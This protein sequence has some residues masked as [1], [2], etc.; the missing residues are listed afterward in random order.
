MTGLGPGDRE[1]A[2]LASMSEAVEVL[3]GAELPEADLSGAIGI[4]SVG[5]LAVV[6]DAEAGRSRTIAL[7][8]EGDALALPED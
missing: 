6:V 2:Q 3:A 8:Q 1:F 7:L 5:R 4:V